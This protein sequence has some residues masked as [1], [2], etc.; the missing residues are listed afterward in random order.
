MRCVAITGVASGLGQRVLARLA[1]EGAVERVIGIDEGPPAF[2]PDVLEHHAL[3]LRAA[4]LKPLLEGCDTLIHLAWHHEGRGEE[5]NRRNV[6]ALRRTLD[7]SGAAGVLSV[8]HLSSATVY[9]AWPDNA[10]PLREEAAIR[11][12]PGFAHAAEQAEC[13]R[14]LAEWRD[15]HPGTRV[16]VL[17][18]TVVLGTSRDETW[19]SRS[20]GGTAAIRVRSDQPPVQ[21]VHADDVASAVHLAAERRLDGAFNVAPDGWVA[22]DTATE[23]AGGPPRVGLPEPIARR[24]QAVAWRLGLTD[25][26]PS[27]LPY[28]THPWAVANDRLRAEGWEPERTNEEVLVA[29]RPGSRWRE[30]SPK[31]R[32]EI[33][34]AVSGTAIVGLVAGVVAVLRRRRTTAS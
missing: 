29:A 19:L 11:P 5:M 12:N 18:P 21:F 3:D 13:E 6:D 17:R 25:R 28:L 4:D 26:P 32:Q 27:L 31:R 7:A 2:R 9:G 24:V 23:L 22:G 16:A 14:L 10:V 34:L 30:L 8:V 20:L 1:V 15:A 33:A